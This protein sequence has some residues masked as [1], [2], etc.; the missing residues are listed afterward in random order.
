MNISKITFLTLI[1]GQLLINWGRPFPDKGPQVDEQ[2]KFG[3]FCSALE[4]HSSAPDYIVVTVKNLNTGE[5]KEICTHGPNLGMAIG[6]E[7]DTRIVDFS[8]INSR[9]FQFSSE[10]A[11]RTIGFYQ[12]SPR[13]LKSYAKTMDLAEIVSQVKSGEMSGKTFAGDQ[14][15]QTMFAHLMFNSGVM[16]RQ[17]CLAG[18]VCSLNYFID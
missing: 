15:E 17:G 13:E 6:Y 1:F 2:T 11:L 7:S 12:Y 9:Y 8:H 3:M 4:Y 18:N 16:V 14:K 10:S 5:T